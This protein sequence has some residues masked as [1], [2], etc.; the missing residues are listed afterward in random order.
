MLVKIAYSARNSARTPLFCSN[1]ARWLK[2]FPSHFRKYGREPRPN[3]QILIR[4][5]FCM[6]KL[7][8][9]LLYITNIR[10]NSESCECVLSNNHINYKLFSIC[11]IFSFQFF[12]QLLCISL[13][14]LIFRCSAQILLKKCLFCR[15][16]ARLKNRLFCSKFCRQNLSKPTQNKQKH[17]SPL[18]DLKDVSSI[19]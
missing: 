17:L 18:R 9:I 1:S 14:S 2:N 12:L 15:Q 3:L 4:Y 5:S 13:V 8:F 6:A 7:Q 11:F 10:R 19:L 16:N